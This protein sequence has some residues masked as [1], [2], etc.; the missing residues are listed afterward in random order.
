MYGNNNNLIT[1]IS[2][3]QIATGSAVYV[4]HISRFVKGVKLG[5]SHR[6]VQ[7]A[8]KPLM[9][10]FETDSVLKFGTGLLEDLRLLRY[11]V[12]DIQ[13]RSAHTPLLP[14]LRSCLILI[15]LKSLTAVGAGAMFCAWQAI[16]TCAAGMPNMR[17]GQYVVHKAASDGH[18]ANP[19]SG[20]SPVEKVGDESA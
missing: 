12:P 3:L 13:P 19:S 8:L 11:F 5:G 16:T 4:F 15:K 14:S 1:T 17:M 10:L 6:P 20:L 18:L 9:P 2:V 7:D